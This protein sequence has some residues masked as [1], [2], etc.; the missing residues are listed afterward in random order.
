MKRI[1]LLLNVI[2]LAGAA[3]LG[4]KFVAG[5]TQHGTDARVAVIL[6]T[7]ERDGVLAEMRGM[8]E[9]VQAVIEA[10][11]ANEIDTIPAIVTPLGTAATANESI[12]MMGKLPLEMKSLGFA[13]H[14]AMDD[15][16]ALAS[17]GA[18][19]AEILAQLGNILANCTTCHA[20]YSLVAQ[21]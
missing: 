20:A 16:A 10:L 9:G 14:G 15:L 21:D 1:S 17:G 2:L 11:A 4:Y 5:A 19:Q 13:A 6:T 3:F 12:V 8:L 7:A 18:S